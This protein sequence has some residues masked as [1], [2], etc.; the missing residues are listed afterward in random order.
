MSQTRENSSDSQ[1]TPSEVLHIAK[2][3]RLRMSDEDAQSFARQLAGVVAHFR[4]F[5]ALN[6]QGV[7]PMAHPTSQALWLEADEPR[8]PLPRDTLLDM[9]PDS[10]PPFIKTPKV[11]PNEAGS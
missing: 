10:A 11:L 4:S 2:L 7:E 1:I 5:Q 6:L 8:D 9:A 3:A